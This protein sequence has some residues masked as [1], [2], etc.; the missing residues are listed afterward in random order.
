MELKE[1]LKKNTNKIETPSF[2]LPP[3]LPC[4]LRKENLVYITQVPKSHSSLI[5]RDEGYL[6]SG[7]T[8]PG[9]SRRRG[10]FL[11]GMH[12]A[13]QHDVVLVGRSKRT[14]HALIGRFASALLLYVTLQVLQVVVASVAVLAGV[15]AEAARTTLTWMPNLRREVLLLA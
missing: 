13:M 11:I 12:S 2:G 5:S 15:H 3:Y 14:V 7:S 10:G 6:V 8:A 9:A 4:S 1:V